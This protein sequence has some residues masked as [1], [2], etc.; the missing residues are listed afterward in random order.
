MKLL[1]SLTLGTAFA[2]LISPLAMAA[3]L[4]MVEQAGCHWCE[5]W[6][7]DI[8]ETYPKTEEGKK[9]P[10]RR[11]DLRALPEDITFVSHLGKLLD[12][13]LNEVAQ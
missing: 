4:V 7:A 12:E 11:V 2:T 10:L 13:N 6:N 1:R 8:S 3:E 5:R 9:A